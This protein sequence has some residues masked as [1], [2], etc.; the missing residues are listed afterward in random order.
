MLKSAEVNFCLKKCCI[1][2]WHELYQ[3]QQFLPCAMIPVS[4]WCDGFL[5]LWLW[6][7]LIYHYFLQVTRKRNRRPCHQLLCWRICVTRWLIIRTDVL[8]PPLR[9]VLNL[10][11]FI[12]CHIVFLNH[13][14]ESFRKSITTLWS[15]V[16]TIWERCV[17]KAF[18]LCR[19]HLI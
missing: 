6:S 19:W 3:S 2:S 13:Y 5:C 10:S 8:M 17:V 7:Y 11:N 12:C 1:V 15:S 16:H 18:R 14:I 9:S 4:F